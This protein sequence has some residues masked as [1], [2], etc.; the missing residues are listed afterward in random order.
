MVT[1][2]IKTSG[3]IALPLCHCRVFSHGGSEGNPISEFPVRCDRQ[4]MKGTP[5][6]AS[7]TLGQAGGFQQ[8]A[9]EPDG[10]SACPEAAKLD[11]TNLRDPAVSDGT[12]LNGA[13]CT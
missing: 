1:L 7:L 13:S 3:L 10:A 12:F 6:A 2:A 9:A 8:A 5:K 4:T 11:G